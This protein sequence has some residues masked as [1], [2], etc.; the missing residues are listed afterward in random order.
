LGTATLSVQAANGCG[1]GNISEGFMIQVDNSIGVELI[2]L[3][4]VCIYPNPSDGIFVITSNQA[5]SEVYLYDVHGRR[6]YLPAIKNENLISVTL[7]LADGLYFVHV[8]IA[9]EWLVK[10]ISIVQ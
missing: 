2:S 6:L 9:N 3:S 5:I 1:V 8:C 4:D 10:K 7:N